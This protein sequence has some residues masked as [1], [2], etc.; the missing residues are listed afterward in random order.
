MANKEF[1]IGETLE[2]EGVKL[3]VVE[4]LERNCENC[5]FYQINKC[6]AIDRKMSKFVG[7]CDAHERN[8]KNYVLYTKAK[9]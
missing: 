6:N 2:Y 7:L 3:K 8:D 1:K 9:G 5:Y 4:D